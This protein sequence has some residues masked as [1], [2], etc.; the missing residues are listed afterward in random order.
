VARWLAYTDSLTDERNAVNLDYVEQLN[1]DEYANSYRIVAIMGNGRKITV[2]D[3]GDVT[4]SDAVAMHDKLLKE[5][6]S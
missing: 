2:I 1:L 3:L 6:Q 5:I 4:R